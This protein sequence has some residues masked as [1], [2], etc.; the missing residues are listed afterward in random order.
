MSSV[1]VTVKAKGKRRRVLTLPQGGAP[2][3][4]GHPGAGVGTAVA[5]P[6]HKRPGGKHTVESLKE[7][8]ARCEAAMANPRSPEHHAAQMKKLEKAR[9][10][11]AKMIQSTEEK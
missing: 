3:F 10:K 11:L 8:I 1:R 7:R 4:G 5:A 6:V 2:A 9:A